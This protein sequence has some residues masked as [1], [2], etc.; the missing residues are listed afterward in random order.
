MPA[1]GAELK[2]QPAARASPGG[3]AGRGPERVPHPPGVW[4]GCQGFTACGFHAFAL[5]RAVG[6]PAF[7]SGSPPAS[8]TEPWPGPRGDT[9][10]G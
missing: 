4:T 2:G 7:P 9:D 1:E 10:L 6:C 3:G 8:G 5:T